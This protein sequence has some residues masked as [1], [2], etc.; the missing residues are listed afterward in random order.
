MRIPRDLRSQR[1]STLNDIWGGDW[2]KTLQQL[3]SE[4]LKERKEEAMQE[5]VQQVEDKKKRCAFLFVA[6][7][8]Y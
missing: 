8:V 4:V 5:V 2:G 1:M 7:D 3:K 6:V